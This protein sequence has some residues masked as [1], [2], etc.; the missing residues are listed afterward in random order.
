MLVGIR[1]GIILIMTNQRIGDDPL[2]DAARHG[3]APSRAE[4]QILQQSV[5]TQ[6][7]AMQQVQEALERLET[8][9]NQACRDQAQGDDGIRVRA[10]HWPP[11]ID[12]PQPFDYNSDDEDYAGEVFGKAHGAG[13]R[14]GR[15]RG[16]HRGGRGGA[17]YRVYRPKDAAFVRGAAGHDD[18]YSEQPRHQQYGREEPKK[19]RMKIDLLSFDGHLHIEYFFDW[20]VEVERLFEYMSI[21]KERKVKLVAYKFKGGASAWWERLQLSQSREGKGPVIS[22]LK[23]KRLLNARFLPPDFEQ[24]LFQQ[25]QECWQGAHTVQAYVDDFYRL[26]ARNDLMETEAQQVARFIGGLRL[27]IHDKVSM[28]HVFTLTEVVSLNHPSREAI[29]AVKNFNS[30]VGPK[31]SCL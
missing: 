9:F 8:G 26:S 19:Y 30:G 23:M 21:P 27:P 20:I 4:F 28:Q 29:G 11:P 18:V 24:R 13:P 16:G 1:A 14:G 2:Y 3:E 10:I 12:Q 22:W 7:Q 17:G 6:Q 15:H 5:Q 25:Y 31:Q